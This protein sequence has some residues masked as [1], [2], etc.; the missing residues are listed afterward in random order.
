M[1]KVVWLCSYSDSELRRHLK[2][3]RFYWANILRHMF[4]MD[5]D[6][7]FAVW[8]SN[9]IR[10]FEKMDTDIELHIVAPHSGITELNEFESRGV[11]YHIFWSE[12][13]IISER[14]KR[15]L[16]LR[17]KNSFKRHRKII[18]DL[19]KRIQPDIVHVIGIENKF[20]SLAVLDI[21]RSTPV[22]A[23]LQT[24]VNDERFRANCGVSESEYSYD[25]EM[26]RLIIQRS[27]YIGT[28]VTRFREIITQK[29]K[30]D[31]KFVETTLA[32]AEPIFT[33]KVEKEY[34][35]VYFA[36][37]ISKAVDL[38]IEAF[39]IAKKEASNLTLD[40]VGAYSPE[41]KDA[42][43]KRIQELGISN[44]V[45][46]E[47]KLPTH[48]DVIRQIR[49]SRYALLPLKID[50]VSGTIRESQANGLPVIT[51]ITPYTPKLNTKFETVLVSEVGDHK[52][53]AKNMLRI[54]N[55]VNFA[56]ILRENG[57][58][59]ARERVSNRVVVE[60]YCEAY[61]RLLKR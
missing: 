42:L 46:F 3:P 29:I 30:P 57:Y 21:P 51:T 61:H 27:D 17:N 4:H 28:K 1:I 53:M 45:F 18:H 31:A 14:I 55:D 25:S 16:N 56:E 7:D 23:Q 13:D 22:V 48:E 2:S 52:A 34:D 40:I 6:V 36:A 8:D 10:E 58:K 24:L 12:W 44:G 33:D 15:R 50:L 43:D 49:K 54:A 20:Y 11:F 59:L 37:N 32:I 47:G 5:K 41:L 60:H 38:A 35:F 19:L 26:E 9:A 39:A